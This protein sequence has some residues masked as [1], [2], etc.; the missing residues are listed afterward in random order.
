[1][2]GTAKPGFY[3]GAFVGQNLDWRNLETGFTENAFGLRAGQIFAFARGCR[4]AD[5]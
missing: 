5:G 1:M 2:A 4:I 3:F